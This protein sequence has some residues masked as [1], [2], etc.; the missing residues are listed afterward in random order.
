MKAKE[1][2]MLTAHSTPAEE[3]NKASEEKSSHLK[4]I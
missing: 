2:N 3:M 1:G 4:Q